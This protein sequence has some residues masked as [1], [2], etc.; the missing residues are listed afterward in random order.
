MTTE[1]SPNDDQPSALELKDL[2]VSDVIRMVRRLKIS[3]LALCLG[4][5]ASVIGVAIGYART[6]D[7]RKLDAM[8]ADLETAKAKLAEANAR[9][10]DLKSFKHNFERFANPGVDLRR[11]VK[12]I[13]AQMPDGLSTDDEIMAS[14]LW[15]VKGQHGVAVFLTGAKSL[16]VRV[17]FADGKVNLQWSEAGNSLVSQLQD[18][19]QPMSPDRI[20]RLNSQLNA[21]GV[22]RLDAEHYVVRTIDGGTE[23]IWTK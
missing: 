3:A 6:L 16:K 12:D 8:A 14:L 11:V 2:T 9:S 17:A 21:L 7:S 1:P 20:A 23:F 22:A 5:A 13:Q 10:E 4:V 15:Q 19:G 18:E